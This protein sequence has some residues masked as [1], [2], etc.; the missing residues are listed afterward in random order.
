MGKNNKPNNGVRVGGDVNDAVIV[1]GSGNTIH[2]KRGEDFSK[3]QP[4]PPKNKIDTWQT[5]GI[6][7]IWVAPIS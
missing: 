6:I 2:I 3:H 1:S 4:E 5:I 7:F